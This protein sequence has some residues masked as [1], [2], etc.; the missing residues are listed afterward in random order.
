MAIGYKLFKIK[1]SEKGKLFPLYVYANEELPVGEWLKAKNG[2]QREGKV[3]SKLGLL[4][5][6]PGFHIN[7]KVPYVSHIGVK[8]NGVIKYMHP[9]TVWCEVEYKD[10][11]DYSE[12]AKINGT[13]NGKYIPKKACLDSIPTNGYYKYKTNP[14][15][16]GEWIIAGEMKIN[17]LLTDDEVKEICNSNGYDALPRLQSINL[18]EYGF[19]L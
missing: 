18:Q 12:Q 19:I 5:Y 16:T 9:D 2:E 3:I 13:I 7:D 17:R 15:M 14:N 8:E 6:R 1:K 11:I 10:N 4:K